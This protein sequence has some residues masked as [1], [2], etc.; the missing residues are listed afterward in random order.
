MVCRQEMEAAREEKG[1]RV[2][3]R[4]EMSVEVA[5]ETLPK[6]SQ[7]EELQVLQAVYKKCVVILIA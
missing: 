6:L 7:K 4:P 5:G 1:E 2:K 3:D